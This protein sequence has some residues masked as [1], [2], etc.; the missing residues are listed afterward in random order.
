MV[1]IILTIFYLK[2]ILL[3]C[4]SRS[5][6]LQSI[7]KW[8]HWW[9]WLSRPVV[10]DCSSAELECSFVRVDSP[11][12]KCHLL[13]FVTVLLYHKECHIFPFLFLMLKFTYCSYT[14]VVFKLGY[15]CIV[16]LYVYSWYSHDNTALVKQIIHGHHTIECRQ[17]NV[18]IYILVCFN[19]ST[20]LCISVKT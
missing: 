2:A 14:R 12:D 4:W 15:N 8:Y 20:H 7:Y 18:F 5:R 10:Q 3:V 11:I 1:P 6:G 17:G 13:C 16:H 9:I 19:K